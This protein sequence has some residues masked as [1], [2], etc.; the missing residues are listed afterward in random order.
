MLLRHASKSDVPPCPWLS[1]T[2]PLTLP[3]R[4]ANGSRQLGSSVHTDF[5]AITLLLQEGNP[6]LEVYDDVSQTW[7]G[8]EPTGN[9]YIVNVGDVL[10]LWAGRQSKSGL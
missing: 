5:S 2:L 10:E 8:I 9:A 4:L 6:G 7:H 1:H 3:T